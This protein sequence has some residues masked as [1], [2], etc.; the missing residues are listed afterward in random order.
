MHARLLG[1]SVLGRS[2]GRLEPEVL[3]SRGRQPFSSVVR[4]KV[5]NSLRVP[6]YI[7]HTQ[8]L[9]HSKFIL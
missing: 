2:G 5:A 7:Q 8:L 1:H 6:A 9:K 3:Q 4:N